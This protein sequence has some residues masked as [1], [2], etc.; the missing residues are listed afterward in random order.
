M[1]ITKQGSNTKISVTGKDIPYMNVKHIYDLWNLA[2]E[3]EKSTDWYADANGF[4]SNLAMNYSLQHSTVAN[5]VA[6]ISPQTKWEQN[7]QNATLAVQGWF[8]TR[9]GWVN[10]EHLPPIHKFSAMSENGYRCLFGEKFTLG[11]KTQS[12]ALNLQGN[13]HEVTVDSLAMSILLGLY[14]KAGSYKIANK[15]YKY[16]QM[17]YTQVA[18]DLGVLPAHLQAVVWVVCRRLKKAD[19]GYTLLHV[20]TILGRFATPTEVLQWL[21]CNDK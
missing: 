20:S 19:K 7:L 10:R 18:N 5:M 2:T 12:F 17:L 1:L 8:A 9:E 6:A 4:V 3:S 16:A 21:T 11:Q 15:A 13:M 14:T